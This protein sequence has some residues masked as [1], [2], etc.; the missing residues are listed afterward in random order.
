[1]SSTFAFSKVSLCINML[2]F[3]ISLDTVNA[4]ISQATSSV[5]IKPMELYKLICM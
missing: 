3:V 5:R 2:V 4:M 1:M